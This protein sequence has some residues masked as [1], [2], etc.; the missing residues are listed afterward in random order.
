MS[1][2]KSENPPG[3]EWMKLEP[4]GFFAVRVP[5]RPT[6]HLLQL[7]DCD[8]ADLGLASGAVSTMVR[9]YFQ[10]PLARAAIYLASPS[11][12]GS[13]EKLETSR[14]CNGILETSAGVSLLRYLMRMADRCT[15]FGLFAG[16]S[17]GTLEARTGI[18][19]R[20]PGEHTRYSILDSRDVDIL[21]GELGML[22]SAREHLEFVR[23]TDIY[24]LGEK[25]RYLERY[26]E[27]GARYRIASVERSDLLQE[28][29]CFCEA[30]RTYRAIADFLQEAAKISGYEVELSEVEE[31]IHQAI[32]ERLLRGP[33]DGPTPRPDAIRTVLNLLPDSERSELT[34]LLDQLAAIDRSP[35]DRKTVERYRRARKSLSSKYPETLDSHAFHVTL[36]LGCE[37]CQLG[38]G[39][40]TEIRTASEIL[41]R[42]TPP[43][44][45]KI[46]T[47]FASR[48]ANRFGEGRWIPLLAALD[49]ETG[50]PFDGIGVEPPSVLRNLLLGS[51]GDMPT[52]WRSKAHETLAT[53]V[54]ARAA[55]NQIEVEL[56]DEDL[57]ENPPNPWKAPVPLSVAAVCQIA[58]GSRSDLD[59][60]N[61]RIVLHH[62]TGPS[63]ACFLAR[64]TPADEAL[65]DACRQLC[66][67]EASRCPDKLVA[68]IV[69]F[70]EERSGNVLV[71]ES[72]RSHEIPVLCAGS[73]GAEGRVRLDQLL[74]TSSQGAVHLWSTQFQMLV[75]PML[76]NAH[77][78]QASKLSVYR[79][80]ASLQTKVV[81][82]WGWG[83]FN[84]LPFKPRIV[85]GRVVLS[86]AE[87]TI[88][89]CLVEEIERAGNS[90]IQHSLVAS[91]AREQS[92]PS[93]VYYIHEERRTLLKLD[94]A[95]GRDLLLDQLS[96]DHRT[97][98]EAIPSPDEC[99]VEGP[100]G[101]Y[102]S[103]FVVP[104]LVQPLPRASRIERPYQPDPGKRTFPPGS[105]WLYLKFFCGSHTADKLLSGLIQPLV[106]SAIK[107]GEVASWFFVRYDHPEFHI[108][109]RLFGEPT[110]LL[111]GTL[112]RLRELAAPYLESGFLHK[113]ELGTYEREVE[114]YGGTVGCEVAERLF[115]F[116]SEAALELLVFVDSST[117]RLHLCAASIDRFL[118]DS[119]TKEEKL[120]V[121][122]ML[123]KSFE[124]EFG[125][126]GEPRRALARS[127][128]LE[129]AGLLD[130]LVAVH[131]GAQGEAARIKKVLDRRAEKATPVLARIRELAQRGELTESLETLFL[132]YTHML[133]NRLIPSHTRQ[134]ELV[135]YNFL[136]RSQDALNHFLAA[137]E[138]ASAGH[139]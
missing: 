100:G 85:R 66:E 24:D 94:T 91:W 8:E 57:P 77:G 70:S 53:R 17:H 35:I 92:V 73:N 125:I 31:F 114:R 62:V 104:F 119:L 38:D 132:S 99:W 68:D 74:V 123:R 69:H 113:L 138:Q 51:D 116:D 127:Y 122:A 135:L 124:T 107:T 43:L 65:A 102:A 13:L 54:L 61:Y 56:R 49:E 1:R 12:Y 23:C 6:A 39:I 133:A 2:R 71:S 30:P 75:R 121:L 36:S 112:V 33:L 98:Q 126:Q 32:D 20:E 130:C 15:P 16:C 44:G 106:R 64:F 18:C 88:P 79:F 131:Q 84:A 21:F 9:E 48:L 101:V 78:H 10:D 19:I 110:S 103:E 11:L 137:S 59:Q 129:R 89:Q 139:P 134:M 96:L 52:R 22:R 105:E 108:R 37:P 7:F 63:G 50:V 4:A 111:G 109:L 41:R 117:T 27:G 45:H 42:T 29:L 81:G 136:H 95:L 67:Q 40:V 86:P 46:L 115:E 14:D 47:D 128:R 97:I 5:S 82:R 83:P 72:L 58:S 120:R 34:D 55:P 80:L 90:D 76:T 26:W 3:R 118:A 60:G 93:W 87:W 25:W 28:M